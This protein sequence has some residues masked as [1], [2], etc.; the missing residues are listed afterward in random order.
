MCEEIGTSKN[1]F[2]FGSC[3]FS[4]RFYIVA[5]YRSFCLWAKRTIIL[6]SV[7]V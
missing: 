5:R 4:S 7:N 2:M 3:Q 6:K 1:L